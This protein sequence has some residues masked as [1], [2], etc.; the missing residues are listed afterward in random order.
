MRRA[1]L[2]CALVSTLWAAPDKK[3]PD[4]IRGA[5]S[6]A[7]NTDF[8]R[9]D[10]RKGGQVILPLLADVD[11]FNPFLTTSASAVNVHHLIYPR[12]LREHADYHKAPSTYEPS[13]VDRWKQDGLK[14]HM[15]VRDKAVWSDGAPI[16]SADV[17]FSW[18]AAKSKDVAWANAYTVD[19]IKDVEIVD[20]KNVV[21]HF[22]EAYPEML[23]DTRYMRVIPKHVYGKVPFKEWKSYKHWDEAA[24]VVS[25]PY[26]VQSYKHNEEFIL[27]P[28]DRFWDKSRPRLQRVIFRVIT[29]RQ[30]MFESLMAGELDGMTEVQPKHMK[31]VLEDPRYY[32]YTLTA[33]TYAYVGWNC[34]SEIFKDDRT[35]RAM[36]LA[37]DRENIV[38][39]LLYGQGTLLSSPLLTSRWAYDRSLEPHPFDPDRAVD[40]LGEA[41]W[42]RGKGGFLYRGR[43]RFEFHLATNNENERRKKVVQLIQA[44]LKEIGVVAHARFLDFNTMT[45]NLR[46]GK[47]EAWILGWR[48]SSK[49]DPKALFH[50]TE[51]DNYNLGRWRNKEAD[52]LI[53]TARRETDIPRAKE[54]WKKWQA[55]FHEEQPYTLLYEVRGLYA[56]RKRYRDV[57]MNAI[58]P[59]YNIDSW[60]IVPR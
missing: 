32:L 23:H 42:R 24:A 51:T 29:S 48:M 56:L 21:V 9:G 26:K 5:L 52:A 7:K 1:L 33:L 31:K 37:I 54:L 15:H 18:Q 12:A 10:V 43:Q 45:E 20:D 25:G 4:E 14:I 19:F 53:D 57:E 39:S 40:L 35:R 34:E 55:V 36:T 60:F 28:N 41:G 58:N 59:Y 49:V 3:H 47:E 8:K 6:T 17:R 38:E 13:L 27:V 11:S 30:T 22:A 2:A 46:Q 50:S 44:D 16:T